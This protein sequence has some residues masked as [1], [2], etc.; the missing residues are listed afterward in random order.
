MVFGLGKKKEATPAPM[1]MSPEAMEMLNQLAQGGPAGAAQAPTMAAPAGTAQAVPAAG[2]MTQFPTIVAGV[3]ASSDQAG[4]ELSAKEQRK[5]AREEKKAAAIAKR[6][7]KDFQRRRKRNTKA[8]FSR[9]RYLRDANGNAASSVALGGVFL[10]LTIILPL[11][12]NGLFLLPATRSNQEIIEEV[13]SLQALVDQAQPILKAA[14]GQKS[15]REEALKTKLAAFIADEEAT[16]ALRQFVSELQSRGAAL[17]PDASGTVVNTDLE[18]SGLT[19]KSLTLEMKVDFLDYLLVRNRFVRT[20]PR[21]NVSEETIVATPGNP[22]VD[23]KLV[24][25]VPAR[26]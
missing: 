5:Q 12:I 18:L 9:A 13:R 16:G 19:G 25:L 11:V 20:Q 15:E 17:K 26:T 22:I 21:I 4:V 1:Q 14:I 10:V 2:G 6:E 24:L 3:S 23:I 7:E 8:R